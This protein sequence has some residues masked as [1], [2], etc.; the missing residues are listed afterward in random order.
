[1][2]VKSVWGAP[3]Q[4]VGPT[5]H[6]LNWKRK[7][8]RTNIPH[9]PLQPL[10]RCGVITGKGGET[11]RCCSARHYSEKKEQVKGPLELE[12]LREKKVTSEVKKT[13][14]YLKKKEGTRQEL[15]AN[16]GKK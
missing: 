11:E 12:E 14:T 1:M 9:R 6:C 8:E 7:R 16:L 5:A 3:K 15:Q 4:K 13:E 2:N 10:G